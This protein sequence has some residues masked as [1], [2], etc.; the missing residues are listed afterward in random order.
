M[1]KYHPTAAQ[2]HYQYGKNLQ[3]GNGVPP[4]LAASGY[5]PKVLPVSDNLIAFALA[6][7][8]FRSVSNSDDSDETFGPELFY[9]VSLLD[10]V[11]AET[12]KFYHDFGIMLRNKADKNECSFTFLTASFEIVEQSKKESVY[13][14]MAV[15]DEVLGSDNVQHHL[16]LFEVIGIEE[17]VKMITSITNDR[18]VGTWAKVDIIPWHGLDEVK[19]VF[20]GPG[21]VLEM[22]VIVSQEDYNELLTKLDN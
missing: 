7:L 21:S 4:E 18:L 11:F 14:Y 20:S 15:L 5:W 13:N 16:T 3:I 8:S 22:E 17:Y 6:L 19:W 10:D 2:K 1:I 9:N 12:V